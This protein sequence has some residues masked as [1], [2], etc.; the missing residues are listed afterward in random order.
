MGN[1]LKKEKKKK[2][3]GIKMQLILVREEMVWTLPW[4]TRETEQEAKNGKAEK[5]LPLI[6]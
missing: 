2:K 5:T 4:S 3:P 1:Y 6:F